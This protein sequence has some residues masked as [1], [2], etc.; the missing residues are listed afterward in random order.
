MERMTINSRSEEN[1]PDKA[2]KLV[3]LERGLELL[4]KQ[5][6]LV[7]EK[8]RAMDKLAAA[9]RDRM[10]RIRRRQEEVSAE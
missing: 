1:A 5:M 9:I 10:D 4:S 7:V 8:K 6:E 3:I 2:A